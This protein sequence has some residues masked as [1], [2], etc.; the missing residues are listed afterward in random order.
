MSAPTGVASASLLFPHDDS[1]AA[2]T[3]PR[4]SPAS[5]DSGQSWRSYASENV[6][7]Q[8]R[9]RNSR[10]SASPTND[11]GLLWVTATNP[12]EFKQKKVMRKVRK[13]AMNDHL[14]KRSKDVTSTSRLENGA[15]VPRTG[16][17]RLHSE[18]SSASQTID[19]DD[20]SPDFTPNDLARKLFYQ[21]GRRPSPTESVETCP[22]AEEEEPTSSLAIQ[23]PTHVQREKQWEKQM[24][25]P[26][27]NPNFIQRSLITAS[28]RIQLPYDLQ[29]VGPLESIGTPLDPFRT[30]PQVAHPRVSIEQ[31]KFHCSRFFGTKA[32]G[33]SWVPA[34]IR[35]RHAFLST[36]CV[37]STHLD[38]IS[39]LPT[40]SL[41]TLAIRQEVI[42]LIGRSLLHPRTAVDDFTIIALVQLIC[43][44]IVAG[45]EAALQYHEAGMEAMVK[46]RGGLDRLGVSGAL[47]SILTA[48]SFQSAIFRERQPRSMYPN[49]CSTLPLPPIPASKPIPESPLFCP[50]DDFETIKRSP[51]CFKHTL[52]LL[53]DVRDMT[54]LF[55]DTASSLTTSQGRRKEEQLKLLFHKIRS[56]PSS[57]QLRANNTTSGDWTYEACRIAAVIQATAIIKRIPFSQ[58]AVVATQLQQYAFTTNTLYPRSRNHSRLLTAS[59]GPTSAPFEPPAPNLLQQLR[60]ALENSDLSDCWSDMAGVLFWVSLVGGAAARQSDKVL[61]KWIVAMA[62]RCSVVLAFEHGIAV[63]GALRRLLRVMEGVDVDGGAC[64]ETTRRESADRKSV[65]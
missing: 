58:T 39:N 51:R 32:M 60:T 37:A 53:C 55:L 7:G 8:Q 48:V 33:L 42:H 21:T 28:R 59:P 1:R 9:R 24:M 64:E 45:N 2:L 43:S 36:L 40:E 19:G 13:Q 10:P 26:V 35:S 54:E 47:A 31:L 16:R 34:L 63:V 22:I 50:R 62:V 11:N 23:S 18:E 15:R 49:Y 61:R 30:M 38:A 65:V 41:E 17:L 5:T 27:P 56:L 46:Q 6:P 3:V 44:E 52:D 12:D 14:S 25:T 20:Q 4:L 57:T 29:K